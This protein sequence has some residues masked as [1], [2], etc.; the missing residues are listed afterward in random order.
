MEKK[1]FI[2]MRRRKQVSMKEHSLVSSLHV[3]IYIACFML[4]KVIWAKS[5]KQK[6]L[7]SN[8]IENKRNFLNFLKLN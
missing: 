4:W 5:C 1:L 7:N 8:R 6:H 2:W 3:R